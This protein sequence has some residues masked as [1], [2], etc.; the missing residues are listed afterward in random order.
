MS[1]VLG[2]RMLSKKFHYDRERLDTSATRSV[3]NLCSPSR[4][5]IL[6]T[7]FSSLEVLVYVRTPLPLF[8]TFVDTDSFFS[9]SFIFVAPKQTKS[10]SHQARWIPWID[11]T[12]QMSQSKPKG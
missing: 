8:L 4:L 6:L 11:R 2:M 3:G 7:R 1:L 12:P 9:L 5:V 10:R